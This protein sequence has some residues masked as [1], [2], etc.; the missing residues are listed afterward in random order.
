[1]VTTEVKGNKWTFFSVTD[2]NFSVQVVSPDVKVDIYMMQGLGQ[3]PDYSS[4]D[5]VLKK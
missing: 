3:I 1:M 4:F 5:G 2:E